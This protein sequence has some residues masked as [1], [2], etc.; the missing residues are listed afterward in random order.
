MVETDTTL[1][2][3]NG[4]QYA[5]KVY[6][7]ENGQWIAIGHCRGINVEVRAERAFDVIAAWRE[8]ARYEMGHF[9]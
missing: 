4:D 1:I 3:V 8:T 6:K 7:Q 5:V 2:A 9:R